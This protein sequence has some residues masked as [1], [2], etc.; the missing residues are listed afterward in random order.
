MKAKKLT[1]QSMIVLLE[2]FGNQQAVAIGGGITVEVSEHSTR[3]RP[4]YGTSGF[5]YED[6]EHLHHILDGAKSFLWWLYRN[7][8]TIANVNK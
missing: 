1:E 2:K 6:S 4:S 8:K 3:F 7:H 5:H